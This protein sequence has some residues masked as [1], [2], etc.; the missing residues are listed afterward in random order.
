[1][2]DTTW[3][4]MAKERLEY[5]R[6][7]LRGERISM[8]ELIELQ[9]LAPYIEPGD[10]ELLEAAGVPEFPE[11]EFDRTK[12]FYVEFVGNRFW[13]EGEDVYCAPLLS[14]NVVEWENAGP[15]EAMSDAALTAL[16]RALRELEADVPNW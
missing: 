7:E 5:L 1:M 13:V 3:R 15:P 4:E 9:G 11:E 14:D 8:G 2:T 16:Y 6:G 10:V 12:A